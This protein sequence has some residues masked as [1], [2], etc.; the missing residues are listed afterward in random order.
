MKKNKSTTN[1]KRTVREKLEMMKQV[2]ERNEKRRKEFEA[3]HERDKN[4]LD[5]YLD[6]DITED[7]LKKRLKE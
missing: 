3:K 1:W 6:G 2:E 5:M 7:E 4:L